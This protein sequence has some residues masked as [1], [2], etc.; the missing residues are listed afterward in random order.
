MTGACKLARTRHCEWSEESQRPPL[1]NSGSDS[2]PHSHRPIPPYE[3][4]VPFHVRP[5][6]LYRNGKTTTNVLPLPTSDSHQMRPSCLS[7]ISLH[8]A[9]P[10]PDPVSANGVP[11]LYDKT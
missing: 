4:Y 1:E 5:L 11:L 3:E 8:R 2:S 10:R 6:L 7:T 9:R